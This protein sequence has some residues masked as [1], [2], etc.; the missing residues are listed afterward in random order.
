YEYPDILHHKEIAAVLA[1]ELKSIGMQ[2][3]VVAGDPNFPVVVG[4]L[5][6]T[7][8]KPSLG[9][10]THYNTV[11]VGNRSKWTVDPFAAVYKAG[12]I[13]GRGASNSKGGLVADIEAVRAI[14]ESGVKLKGDLVIV[15][16]PGEGGTEFAMPWVLKNRPELIKADYYLEGGSGGDFTR[17]QAGHV[18]FKL[19]V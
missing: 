15:S 2:V 12:K 18:W 5:K 9:F 13:Y 1:A 16:M 19:V 17:M 8:G 6:G 7:E 4:R 14:K 3:E 10:A 11:M